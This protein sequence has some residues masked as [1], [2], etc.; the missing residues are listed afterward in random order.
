MDDRLSEKVIMNNARQNKEI[1]TWL[2][3]C[4]IKAIWHLWRIT[5]REGY[6]LKK[7]H[8]FGKCGRIAQWLFKIWSFTQGGFALQ[9]FSSDFYVYDHD[10]QESLFWDIW[11]DRFH[12][13]WQ[14]GQMA[15]FEHL[16]EALAPD[17]KLFS[18]ELYLRR[19]IAYE[20]MRRLG[21]IRLV[22]WNIKKHRLILETHVILLDDSVWE[23]QLKDYATTFNLLLYTFASK[24]YF[25]WSFIRVAYAFLKG[26]KFYGYYIF[27]RFGRRQRAQ[28]SAS[29]IFSPKIGV[30]YA[31]GSD[32]SKRSDL[33][34]LPSSGIN[35]RDILVYFL[36]P[37]YLPTRECIDSLNKLGTQ[38]FSL[39]PR[40]FNAV[41]NHPERTR[42]YYMFYSQRLWLALKGMIRLLRKMR[43]TPSPLRWWQFEKLVWLLDRMAQFEALFLSQ[44][45]KVHFG[46]F[47][48]DDQNMMALHMA[49]ERVNAVD[50]Y[51]HWSNHPEVQML[52]AHDVYFSWGP[53]FQK[54]FD[55]IGHGMQYVFFSGYPFDYT[56]EAV[57]Q[58]ARSCREQLNAKGVR[59]VLSFFDNS[60]HS[61]WGWFS[62]E[63]IIEFYQGLLQKVLQHP[64]W[65][66]II[67]P[68]R[69][70]SFADGLSPEV[71]QMLTKLV[72]E[73]RC[74][75]LDFK[76]FPSLAA[77]ASD[78]AIGFGVFNTS[79][80]ETSLAGVKTITFDP[81]HQRSHPFYK[82]GYNKIVFDDL[83]TMLKAIEQFAGGKDSLDGFGDFSPYLPAI[84]P[85]RDRKTFLRIG[86]CIKSLFDK[87]ADGK[88][89]EESLQ[90]AVRLY[91]E[92][93]GTENVVEY[94]KADFDAFLK[95]K[96]VKAKE[97]EDDFILECKIL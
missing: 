84:D 35:P 75:I 71:R 86:E 87:L 55:V 69:E 90:Y 48:E 57:V 91:R 36:S 43:T 96:T 45:I 81:S 68:K 70:K 83:K 88:D 92:K 77:Q 42:R 9:K 56:F 76:K 19:Q 38:W 13:G 93:Y 10:N 34:W 95:G 40:K 30:F 82:K 89:R 20:Q 85:F 41:F 27:S 39:L 15:R 65:G 14:A 18:L 72:D 44:N 31:Q 63:S 26:V 2:D 12:F 7:V 97:S 54:F 94:S 5:R 50:V 67:K 64:D 1:I 47:S 80:I 3:H 60:Y 61:G 16:T 37:H 32:L 51:V 28:R 79:A 74:L 46:L 29:E 8:Y 6:R 66:L 22:D 11:R 49:G 25:H 33:Y 58:E 52:P 78:V 24:N 21:L 53:Y 62:Q 4:H 59:F 73:G 23:Q 17:Y